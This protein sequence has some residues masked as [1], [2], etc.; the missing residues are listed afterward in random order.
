MRK[1]PERTAWVI[2]WGAFIT[3]CIIFLFVFSTAYWYIFYDTVAF[4]S[5]LTSV[6][7]VVVINDPIL[8]AASS[9]ID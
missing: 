5:E 3:F 4:T 7:G 8:D 2:L 9:V 1:N 6:R